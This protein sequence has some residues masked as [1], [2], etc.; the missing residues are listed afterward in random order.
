MH[1]LIKI[2]MTSLGPSEIGS[3]LSKGTLTDNHTNSYQNKSYR[4]GQLVH[5][6]RSTS[7]GHICGGVLKGIRGSSVDWF[8]FRHQV[9]PGGALQSPG[10]QSTPSLCAFSLV[11]HGT[12]GAMSPAVGTSLSLGLPPCSWSFH[13]ARSLHRAFSCTVQVNRFGDK[14]ILKCQPAYLVH[15]MRIAR[16]SENAMF[17][18]DFVLECGMEH[19]VDPPR[20][21]QGLKEKVWAK[22]IGEFPYAAFHQISLVIIYHPCHD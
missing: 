2:F 16:F 5:L 15:G 12:G 8:Q 9:L 1:V 18:L 19:M 10:G 14:H 11:R 6:P 17:G 7:C 3:F 22:A 20:V 13:V 4:R 21:L